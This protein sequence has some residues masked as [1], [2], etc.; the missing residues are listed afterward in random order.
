MATQTNRA[1]PNGRKPAAAPNVV[2]RDATPEDMEMP[3]PAQADPPADSERDVTLEGALDSWSN[4]VGKEYL[5]W[6]IATCTALLRGAQALRNAQ[7]E[8]AQRAEAAHERAAKDLLT[9]AS[10]GD[11]A[12][13]QLELARADA[14]GATQ[15]WT[16]VGGVVTRNLLESMGQ[17]TEGLTRMNGAVWSAATEWMKVQAA[18]PQTAD[19]L[20]AEVEHVASPLAASPL[21]WPAQEATRQAMTLASSAWNDWLSWSG[22]L[23]DA[24]RSFVDRPATMRH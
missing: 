7:L 16:E 9:V 3:A 20:E 17:L 14:D 13:I 8:A 12:S 22:H 15:Y 23:A 5:A 18:L 19:V 4:S 24:G 21:M 10:L 1:A 2:N 11:L 6:Q